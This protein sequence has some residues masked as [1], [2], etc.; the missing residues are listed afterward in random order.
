MLPPV[1]QKGFEL[2]VQQLCFD[3]E[4]HCVPHTVVPL[5]H[6]AAALCAAAFLIPAAP[7]MLPATDPAT[8]LMTSRREIGLAIAR[9]MSSIR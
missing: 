3:D 6:A 7:R 8:S 1:T 4:Q 5:G 2:V 9:A